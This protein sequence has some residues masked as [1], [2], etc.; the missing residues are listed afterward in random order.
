MLTRKLPIVCIL[1]Y[2]AVDIIR[3]HVSA[4]QTLLV[5]RLQCLPKQVKRIQVVSGCF[6]IFQ[7]LWCR[8]IDMIR[9][10]DD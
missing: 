9:I 2:V 3:T 6:E 1:W 8:F 4:M 7:F 5:T 10:L